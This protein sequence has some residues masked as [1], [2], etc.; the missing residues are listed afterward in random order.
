MQLDRAD[1][2]DLRT[3]E[4]AREAAHEMRGRRRGIARVA[5]QS[6]GRGARV[7]RLPRYL[8]LLP[9]DTLE[10]LDRADGDV[11]GIEHGALLDVE[12][13]EG[14]RNEGSGL[15]RSGIA[16]APEL[17]AEARAIDRTGVE[18]LRKREVARID[19]R[20]QH[21]RL[22]ARAFLVGEDA[23]GE[24]PAR[25][26]AGLVQGLQ[27]LERAKHAVIAVVASAGAD[28]IDVRAAHRRRQILAASAQR[29]DVADGVDAGLQTELSHPAQ[30]EIAAG[31]VVVCEGEAAAGAV[32][33][34]TD[35]REAIQPRFE[36]RPIDAEIA[37][38]HDDFAAAKAALST[39]RR[40]QATRWPGFTSRIS[41]SSTRQRASA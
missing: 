28:G 5:P 29:D 16:D 17:V 31:L 26:E 12:L 37:R 39:L 10:I 7:V 18:R 27:H 33:A 40:W 24:R 32:L 3:A 20:A 22:E 25:D 4:L 9:G 34:G 1:G 41:G 2:A 38:A 8:Q 36:T 13:D 21:V 30:D 23:D 14:V 19:E 6:H 35:L 15:G 11:L